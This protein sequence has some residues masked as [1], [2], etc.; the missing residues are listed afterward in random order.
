MTANKGKRRFAGGAFAVGALCLASCAGPTAGPVQALCSTGSGVQ[1]AYELANQGCGAQAGQPA[2]L[3]EELLLDV[4]IRAFDV[5]AADPATAELRRAEG[6]YLAVG[7]RTA[8][9]ATGAWGAVRVV[10]RPSAA[11]DLG[12]VARVEQS[13]G[14]TLA[15]HLRATDARGTQ[16][17]DERYR[18][19]AK[20]DHGPDQEPFAAVYAAVAD[21]L[22]RRLRAMPRDEL[23]SIRAVAELRFADRI[24]PGAFAGYLGRLE[25]SDGVLG[26]RRLP[27][28]A[29]PMLGHVRQV[30]GRERLFIDTVDEY[31]TNFEHR[32]RRTLLGL[33]AVEPRQRRHAAKPAGRGAGAR[34]ARRHPSALRH[35]QQRSFRRRPGGRQGTQQLARRRRPV[36]GGNPQTPCRSHRSGDGA[37][38][39]RRGW[40]RDAASH[41]GPREQRRH[42]G[43]PRRQAVRQSDPRRCAASIWSTPESLCKPA[44]CRSRSTSPPLPNVRRQRWQAG[45]TPTTKHPR[46]AVRCR[47]PS[48]NC[49]RWLPP[50]TKRWRPPRVLSRQ[51]VSTRPSAYSTAYSTGAH[52]LRTTGA[53]WR[54]STAL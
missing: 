14:E 24:A 18:G 54:A 52:R 20:T 22:T 23:R 39:S 25:E 40:R 28:V 21:D 51:A 2:A 8:L 4:G 12:V 9:Q 41:L 26:T 33:A 43:T 3:P 31:F 11:I 1:A 49:R 32:G 13:D 47:Y 48:A 5:P 44:R 15:L 36:G 53:S 37:N 29:D 38:R 50:S 45:N 46:R 19:T 10:S 30:L 27:A 35:R 34:A 7:L 17:L 42:L 16:W 6:A